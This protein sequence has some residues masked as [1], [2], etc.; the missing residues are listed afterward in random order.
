MSFSQDTTARARVAMWSDLT[1]TLSGMFGASLH[2]MAAP[3]IAT[4]ARPSLSSAPS[5]TA[6]QGTCGANGVGGNASGEAS[7]SPHLH[8][9]TS[10]APASGSPLEV[11]LE[12]SGGPLLS[13]IAW[14]PKEPACAEN[15]TPWL[16][17]LPC[18]DQVGTGGSGRTRGH[19][20]NGV[21][22]QSGTR[23]GIIAWM[24]LPNRFASAI[25]L[26]ISPCSF[27]AGLA[28]L[29][30][31]RGALFRSSEC[32]LISSTFVY[33]NAIALNLLM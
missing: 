14:L 22:N 15:L 25:W 1:H 19:G 9:S 24:P 32:V 6:T 16:K 26:L 13:R 20:L 28:Q 29:L 17:L 12:S 18:R 30:G 10:G 31:N 33:L 5:T 4:H 7:G 21:G 2:Q 23:G 27:Q 11:P 8:G 3:G